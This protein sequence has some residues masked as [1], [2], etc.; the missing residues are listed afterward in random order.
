MKPSLSSK[1][2]PL[3]G[4]QMQHNPAM[5][6]RNPLQP[7]R[8]V[9]PRSLTASVLQPRF[10]AT[11]LQP[12]FSATMLQPLLP[13]IHQLRIRI[14]QRIT[15]LIF[16]VKRSAILKSAVENVEKY[17]KENGDDNKVWLKPMRV[18]FEGEYA[19]DEG[20]PSKVKFN[21]RCIF[22]TS[23]IFSTQYSVQLTSNNYHCIMV[24]LNTSYTLCIPLCIASI[25]CRY[26][27][28]LYIFKKRKHN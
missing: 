8:A 25:T 22:T 18:N 2:L 27:R 7:A 6:N 24:I 11:M 4:L 14:E 10:S 13:P 23:S 26:I 20:G 17:M 5:V 1:P 15:Y 12:R 28:F 16:N 21:C 9:V 19:V 3:P